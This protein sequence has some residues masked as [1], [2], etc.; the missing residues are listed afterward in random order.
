MRGG[1][2]NVL[3]SSDARGLL[4]GCGTGDLAEMS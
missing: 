2:K 4:S 1:G 3:L